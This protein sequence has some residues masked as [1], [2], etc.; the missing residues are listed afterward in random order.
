M[1]LAGAEG[2]VHLL[3]KPWSLMITVPGSKRTNVSNC[4]PSWSMHWLGREIPKQE[5]IYEA[6][7]FRYEA[8]IAEEMRFDQEALRSSKRS[9]Y[10]FIVCGSGPGGSVASRSSENPD[11]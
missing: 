6:I 4:N 10:D 1:Q 9:T 7:D 3:K 8:D 5:A 2:L 11:V